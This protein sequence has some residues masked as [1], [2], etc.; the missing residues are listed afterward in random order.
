MIDPDD[1]EAA[2]WVKRLTVPVSI[3]KNKRTICR[4]SDVV[5]FAKKQYGETEVSVSVFDSDGKERNS[6]T[7][8]MRLHKGDLIKVT[9]AITVILKV[10]EKLSE[11]NSYEIFYA[12]TTAKAV[13]MNTTKTA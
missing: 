4:I 11:N 10:S 7:G 9:G 1:A 12:K 3:N 13:A 6:P 2:K 8:M 5:E